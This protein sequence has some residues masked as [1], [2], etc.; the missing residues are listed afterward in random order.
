LIND[1]NE[2]LAAAEKSV[3]AAREKVSQLENDLRRSGSPSGW[4]R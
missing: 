4:S 2:E 1:K 3:I